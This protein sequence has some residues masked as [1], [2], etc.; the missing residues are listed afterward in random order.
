MLRLSDTQLNHT[1]A[2][3]S[4]RDFIRAGSLGLAG[5]SLPNLL[6]AKE[7]GLPTTGKSVVV[8]FLQGGP[9][10]IETFDPK[11]TAPA[12]IRSITGEVKTSLPGV[13]FGST[14]PK[15]AK[16]AHKLAVV[17]SYGSQNGGHTYEKVMIGG[18]EM[19]ASMGAIYSRVAGTNHPVTAM[20]SNVLILPEAVSPG[21]KLQSNFETGALKSLYPTGELGAAMAPFNP[22][23]GGEMQDNMQLNIEPHRLTDRRGLLARLDNLRRQADKDGIDDM[24][25]FQQQAFDVITRG[26]GTAFDLSTENPRTIARYDTQHLFDEKKLQRWNDMRRT[27]NKLGLQMLMARKMCEAGCGFVTVSDCGWDYHANNNSPKNMAGIYPMGGQVDHA[28]TAFLEDLEARGMSDDVLLIITSEM[29]RTP[30][31][32]KNGG[33]GH[34]GNLT[35]LVFAG[36]GLNMGQVIGESDAGAANPATRGY[37]PQHLLGTVMHTLFDLNKLRVTDGLPNEIINLA[38]RAEPIPELI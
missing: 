19:E 17:R 2:G 10:H 26:V 8:L 13:T 27:T 20:P 35:P 21:L 1:C 23:G 22:A 9:P 12:E 29:G 36:G 31:L 3:Y 33:R 34:Y 24:D 7:S 25:R 14:F 6:K 32:D 30:N 28:V 11:M 15:M 37:T 5:M 38:N 4:R 16:I 18:N